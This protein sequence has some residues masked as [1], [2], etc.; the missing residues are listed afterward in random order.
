MVLADTAPIM[1][2][3]N[4]DFGV[5][6]VPKS[7]LINQNKIKFLEIDSKA[8]INPIYIATKKDH[9][10]SPATKRLLTYIKDYY[11]K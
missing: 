6:I 3:V 7:E 9:F 8:A 2:F 10:L 11:K 5:A 1:N 4:S